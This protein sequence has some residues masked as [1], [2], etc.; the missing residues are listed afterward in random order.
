[1]MFV[2]VY[3]YIYIYIYIYIYKH[4]RINIYI[5]GHA[6]MHF[7]IACAVFYCLTCTYTRSRVHTHKWEKACMS[8]SYIRILLQACKCTHARV[9]AGINMYI[10]H[11]PG[12]QAHTCA[13]WCGHL[14]VHINM[15]KLYV[16]MY[17][18][19]RMHTYGSNGQRTVLLSITYILIYKF[20]RLS[21]RGPIRPNCHF[22]LF[23]EPQKNLN[24]RIHALAT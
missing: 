17:V 2:C 16:C 18:F 6:R 15:S 24:Q 22:S 21:W 8:K 13:C 14:H 11:N 1:M 12:M 10:L 20:L 19:T 7:Y 9:G 3:A 5:Y 23:L 4:T